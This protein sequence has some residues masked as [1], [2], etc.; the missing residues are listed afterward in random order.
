MNEVVI[1]YNPYKVETEFI[2]NGESAGKNT[3]FY[4]QKE[5]VRL[6]EWIEPHGKWKGIFQEIHSYFNSAEKINLKFYGTLQD[7]EDLEC[8]KEKYAEELFK[9]VEMICEG[10]KNQEH[11]LE[12]LQKKFD[13]LMKGPVEELKEEKIKISFNKALSSEF[14][15]TVIAPMSSGKSTL[16]NAI[17]GANILPA[18]NQATTA[19]VCRIKDVDGKQGYTVSCKTK[20]GVTLADGEEATLEK[21]TELN[22]NGENID[23][24]SIEGDIPQISSEEI[25]VVFVDTP[26]GNNSLNEKHKAVMRNAINDENKGMILF[27]FNF[28]QLETDDCD[29]I[30]TLTANAMNNP[31][32]GKKARDRF[33]FVCNKMDELDTEKET[34]EDALMRI[35][36]QLLKKGIEEP[37]IFFVSANICR[38]IRMKQSG[39]YLTKKE[40][41]DLSGYV[42]LFNESDRKLFEFGSTATVVKEKYEEIVQRSSDKGIKDSLEVAEINSGIPA[43]EDAIN[44]YIEKYAVAIKIKTLHDAFM[45]RVVELD[46]INK[47]EQKLVASNEEYEKAKKEFE[48]KQ[49]KYEE[50]KKLEQLKKEIDALKTNIDITDYKAE[51]MQQL[52]K[53]ASQYSSEKEESSVGLE[54]I[55]QWEK[56]VCELGSQVQDNIEKE[57]KNQIYSKCREIIERY[58]NFINDLNQGK[59]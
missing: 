24:I 4:N 38:L 34:Y 27:V 28:T 2:L 36:E 57:I 58:R 51:L 17:L 14:E 30:L 47:Y 3:S 56:K 20:D 25:N 55:R 33:I 53:L 32:N 7:Y 41:R 15:I 52:T 11:R 22:N 12:K 29:A 23:Y 19:T 13:E 31:L 18:L 43:L 54:H 21:I 40:E 35:K 9:D 59:E 8:A 26:G 1:K 42:E 45:K 46:A 16:I 6:Q 5:N 39:D 49:K 37:N 50:N 44:R 48:E 10:G